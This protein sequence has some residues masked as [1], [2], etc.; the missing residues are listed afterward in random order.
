MPGIPVIIAPF[1]NIT[2][3]NCTPNNFTRAATV[4]PAD[5]LPATMEIIKENMTGIC[6]LFAANDA[7]NPYVPSSTAII[8]PMGNIKGMPVNKPLATGV[9]K[10]SINAKEGESKN[11]PISTGIC[12]GRTMGP[13]RL[14]I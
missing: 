13:V 2:G 5:I 14:N 1:T 9:T 7:V 4:S 12:I 3:D 8:I 6:N 10:P 11:P